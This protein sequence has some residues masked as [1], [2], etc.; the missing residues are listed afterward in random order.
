VNIRFKVERSITCYDVDD[1]WKKLS[2]IKSIPEFWHGHREVKVLEKNGNKYKVQIRYAFP[3]FDNGNLGESIIEV[4]EKMK[5]LSFKNY[6]GPIK[7]SIIV[8][9]D[10][11][12]KKIVCVY[13][14]SMSAI[15]LLAKGW[16]E[17]HF[18]QGVEHAFDRLLRS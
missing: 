5:L 15:Y 13:N 16:I 2:D 17:K 3:S 14:V 9:I 4:D 8:W 1:L 11:R 18:K 12:E 7:G 6:K 10:E